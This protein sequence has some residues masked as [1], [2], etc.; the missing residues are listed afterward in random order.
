MKRDPTSWIGVENAT[1]SS[2][3]IFIIRSSN[4]ELESRERIQSTR[5]IRPAYRYF[6]LSACAGAKLTTTSTV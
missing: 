6:S 1:R 5:S 4:P 3:L 2:D